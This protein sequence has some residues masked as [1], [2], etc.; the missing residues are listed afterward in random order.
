MIQTIKHFLFWERSRFPETYAGELNYQCNMVIVPASLI[1][2][3]AWIGYIGPD[4]TI[5]PGKPAIIYLR[6]GLTLISLITFLLQFV[7]VFKRNSMLLFSVMGFYLEVATGIITGITG[8]DPVY[9]AGYFFVLILIIVAP[10]NRYILWLMTLTSVSSFIVT[11]LL[12]GMTFETP[13]QKYTLNDFVTIVVF[14]SVFVYVLDR[15]RYKSWKNSMELEKNREEIARE[16]IK[17]DEIISEAKSLISN[18]TETADFMGK[19]AN[20]IAASVTEQS[21]IV[22]GTMKSSASVIDSF[23][24]ISSN[25]SEQ[26]ESNGNGVV[27]INKLKTEFDD[28]MKSGEAVKKD[29]ASISTLTD[30]CKNKLDNASTTINALKDETSRIAEISGT[31][32][33]IA[34]MTALLS[35]NASIESARAGEH[36]R[37]FAVV[38][39][40]ISK[41]AD[42]S[43]RSAKEI[44]DIIRLSVMRIIEASDQVTETSEILKD[45]VKILVEN[46]KFLEKLTGMIQIM[47]N[48]F[49]ELMQYF[50]LSV[51]YTG[52][53]DDL[54]KKNRD[55]IAT[56][57]DMISRIEKFYS[58]LNKMS[59]DLK[60]TSRHVT[61][62][63]HKLEEILGNS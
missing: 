18:M 21:P 7:P 48:S 49:Q 45:I 57:Q 24:I 20:D 38:A 47:G 11:G 37:G 60:G 4:S 54:T 16:K 33:D 12:H 40:E 14:S 9:M 42:D 29:A 28:T 31:I 44:G 62:S 50:N 17:T 22:A 27:L 56:Y 3:F 53:I 26:M 51:S 55:E 39:D 59:D 41:L 25:T 15:M 5:N 35:L 36:G 32:N 6:I 58:D 8:A 1:C 52:M 46:R 43:M 23:E 30:K 2:I 61:E 34:D 19:F 63:I 10:I 13:K